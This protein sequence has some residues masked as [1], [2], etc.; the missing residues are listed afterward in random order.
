[1]MNK[2]VTFCIDARTELTPEE[3][4]DVKKYELGKQV[5]YNSQRAKEHLNKVEG[6]GLMK[7]IAS[8]AMAKLSLNI[9]VDSLVKGHH[10]EAKDMDEMLGAEEALNAACAHM[11]M[12]LDTAATFDGGEEVREF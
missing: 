6:A 10:I 4:A 12:Y 5:V 11:R 3:T 7:G 9:T 8:L 2:H 1:M